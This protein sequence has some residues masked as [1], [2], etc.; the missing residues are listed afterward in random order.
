MGSPYQILIV[1]D[2]L[3]ILEPLSEYLQRFEFEVDVAENGQQMR[4]LLEQKKYHLIVLDLMLPGESGLSLCRF[5]REQFNTPIILLTA[6]IEQ[7]DR[8]AGLEV[9]ADDYVT[10]PFD[11]R[12]LVARIRSVLRRSIASTGQTYPQTLKK[13]EHAD[14]IYVFDDW[15]FNAT[16]REL[17]NPN[18]EKVVLSSSE[19]SLLYAFVKHANQVLSRETLLDLT[20]RNDA[21]FFDRSIDSQVSRL[22]KK[23]EPDP[24]QP[25]LLKTVR[26]DGYIFT[27]NVTQGS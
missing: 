7:T 13:Y 25:S 1:D 15:S 21:L 27:A 2:H 19:Y 22:R 8:I 16:R 17:S 23:L 20:Q 10:K 18:H 26:G 5:V 24:R 4:K 11:P 9:G 12:E 3:S 6:L 14:E